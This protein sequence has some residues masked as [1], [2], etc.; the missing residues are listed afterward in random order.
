MRIS[1]IG[2]DIVEISKFRDL[3]RSKNKR[4]FANIYNDSEL[5]YCFS[6]KDP[7]PHLAGIFAAKEAVKKASGIFSLS[8][9]EI[10]I[11]RKETGQPVVLLNGKPTQS[12][13]ISI[14]HS[15]TSACAI[16]LKQS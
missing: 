16:A 3:K 12:F 2:I 13:L 9:K 8:L 4:F 10:E 5:D 14:S 7:A 6:Y 15:D 1:G 11:N